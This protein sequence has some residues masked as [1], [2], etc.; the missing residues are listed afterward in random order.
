MQQTLVGCAF[1]D[2]PS[3]TETVAVSDTETSPRP[4]SMYAV[5]H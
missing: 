1:C 5:D 3:G 2:A 4:S